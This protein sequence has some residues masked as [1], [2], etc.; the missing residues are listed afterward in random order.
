MIRDIYLT[1]IYSYLTY[2]LYDVKDNDNNNVNNN[3]NYDYIYDVENDNIYFDKF[4]SPIEENK[5]YLKKFVNSKIKNK[6]SNIST[7]N[8]CSPLFFNW[9]SKN[10]DNS[11]IE[12]EMNV[13]MEIDQNCRFDLLEPLDIPIGVKHLIYG[14]CFDMS[15]KPNIIPNTVTHLIFHASYEAELLPNTL[16]N[17]ITHLTFGENFNRPLEVGFIPSSVKYLVFGKYYDKPLK[18]GVIPF[19][20]THLIFSHFNQPLKIGDIPN[21]VTHLHLGHSFRQKLYEGIIPD[22]VIYLYFPP[23]YNKTLNKNAIP[24]SVKYLKF[25]CCF[26]KLYDNNNETNVH[27]NVK[28][29]SYDKDFETVN[30]INYLP[31]TLLYYNCFDEEMY[32]KLCLESRLKNTLILFEDYQNNVNRI[33][34]GDKLFNIN[35]DNFSKNINL[36]SIVE[37]IER[38]KGKELFGMVILKELTE[39]VFHPDRL[40]NICELYNIEFDKLMEIYE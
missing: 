13:Y 34:L 23:L 26:E 8:F 4:F 38:I 33:K 37:N 22:S 32:N 27:N 21:S 5:L 36:K 19:G 9:F 29:L 2:E 35:F 15:L 11:K 39:K 7:N 28:Y 16:P 20:V 1:F 17:S 10:N 30:S 24:I 6:L 40:L 25:G 31:E 12:A 14:N 18:K 3:N